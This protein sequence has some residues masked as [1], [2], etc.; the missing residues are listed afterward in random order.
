MCEDYPCCGHTDGFGCNY[1]PDMDAIY[2]SIA[3]E[4]YDPY[5]DEEDY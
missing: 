1:E 4:D 5:Y 2:A 3:R